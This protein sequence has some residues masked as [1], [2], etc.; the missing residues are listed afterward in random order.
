MTTPRAQ[1]VPTFKG[2]AHREV[3]PIRVIQ[4]PHQN[5]SPPILENRRVRIDPENNEIYVAALPTPISVF[6]RIANDDVVPE[7]LLHGPE[8]IDSRGVAGVGPSTPSL[9][10]RSTL[11]LLGTCTY[12]AHP[13]RKLSL[14]RP[15]LCHRRDCGDSKLPA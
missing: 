3:P 2:D 15:K 6:D 14:V 9:G 1:A 11:L 12:N 8:A 7:R 5:D 13:R 10:D 4:G